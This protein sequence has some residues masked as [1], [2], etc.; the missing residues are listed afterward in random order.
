MSLQ[1]AKITSANIPVHERIE[2]MRQTV[3]MVAEAVTPAAIITGPGGI[4]KTHEVLAALAELGLNKNED[5]H[6]V[7]GYSSARG[8][9]EALFSNNGTLTVFDDC[10]SALNDR[11]AIELL[12]GALDSY[13]TR[14]I[15][16]LVKAQKLSPAIPDTFEFDG[17]IIFISNMQLERLNLPLRSR[18]LIIDLKMT[19]EEI[20]ARIR[21]I[22]PAIKGF[23]AKEKALAYGFVLEWSSYIRNLN[24]RTIQ[25]VLKIIRAHPVDWQKLASYTVTQ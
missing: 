16:W 11:T 18:C 24:L 22:L 23:S 17:R 25:M 6:F 3:K 14:T 5:Y 7:K 8:L 10:D 12:K 2:L 13:S 19:R 9:F 15:S 21:E 1:P 20:L 4:G